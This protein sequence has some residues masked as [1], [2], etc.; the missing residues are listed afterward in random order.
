MCSPSGSWSESLVAMPP[1]TLP[2]AFNS[3]NEPRLPESTMVLDSS[4]RAIGTDCTRTLEAFR[5]TTG[6]HGHRLTRSSGAGWILVELDRQQL[7]AWRPCRHLLTE[8]M[9]GRRRFGFSVSPLR[10]VCRLAAGE[11][12]E[13]A[14]ASRPALKN[15]WRGA[16]CSLGNPGPGILSHRRPSDGPGATS[17]QSSVQMCCYA[18]F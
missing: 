16:R 12:P 4:T 7:W 1:G 6:R 5:R 13:G 18:A 2:A 8:W 3:A 15:P 14:K 17:S 10:H 11:S 9:P